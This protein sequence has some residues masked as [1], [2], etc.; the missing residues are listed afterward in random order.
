MAG[1]SGA[2]E[3]GGR[4]RQQQRWQL[5]RIKH[6]LASLCLLL[7]AF[8]RHSHSS[9][10]CSLTVTAAVSVAAASAVCHFRKIE[11]Q[12]CTSAI[13]TDETSP[14]VSLLYC[15]AFATISHF[16]TTVLSQICCAWLHVHAACL[17]LLASL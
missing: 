10:A 16:H 5:Q 6:L 3:A 14:S 1:G 12:P 11:L 17:R 15:W 8:S 9:E 7:Q 2:G 13:S 4:R